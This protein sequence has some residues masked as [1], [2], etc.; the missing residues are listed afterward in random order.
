MNTGCFALTLACTHQFYMKNPI[1]I[2]R[3]M[4]TIIRL[5][6]RLVISGKLILRLLP[7]TGRPICISIGRMV[8][9]YWF[10]SLNYTY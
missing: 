4:L 2:Y 5:G 1:R 8:R 10:L 6:V 7:K 9:G 3:R